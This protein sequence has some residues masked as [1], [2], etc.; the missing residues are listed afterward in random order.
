MTVHRRRAKLKQTLVYIDAPQVLLLKA[1]Q[2]T[3]VALAV[4]DE[5]FELPFVAVTVT[6]SDWKKY[7]RGAVDLRYLFEYAQPYTVYMFDLKDIK[8][9]EVMMT[10]YKKAL[11]EKFLPDSRFFVHHH[12][13]D[14]GGFAA[15]TDV[16]TFDID[17]K[18]EL[19]DFSKLY[20][21][22]SDVYSFLLALEKY[23]DQTAP[24]DIRRIV[25]DTFLDQPFKGGF[26]YVNF[27][28][29]L[30]AAQ[31]DNERLSIKSMQY[32]SPG[33]VEVKGSGSAFADANHAIYSF[34]ENFKEIMDQYNK[35]H[36]YLS[37][38]KYL[39]MRATDFDNNTAP[40]AYIINETKSL[41]DL[42]GLRQWG[43]INTLAKHNAL[44][45]AKIVLSYYRRVEHTFAFIAEGR[46]ELL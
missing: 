15:P 6:P 43:A 40:A 26:S 34:G 13:E 42:L 19:N 4:R 39:Q 21:R 2:V 8:D 11:P 25:V 22:Y 37:E 24:R 1:R 20:S 9:G 35:L 5:N 31:N 3:V 38:R 28:D 7:V 17:G 12:T 41:A 45:V 44:A 36:D 46:L 30:T 23:E 27:F 33:T 32:A 18:W 10:P 29:Q 16:Q 14:M